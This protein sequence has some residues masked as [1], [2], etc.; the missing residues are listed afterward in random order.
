MIETERKRDVER[1][2]YPVL[3]VAES[4]ELDLA[5]AGGQLVED[6]GIAGQIVIIL[7]L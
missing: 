6:L 3:A 7:L 4:P 5:T 1:G 2:T